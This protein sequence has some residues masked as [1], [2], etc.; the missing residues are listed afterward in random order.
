MAERRRL[1]LFVFDR[2][3]DYQALLEQDAEQAARRHR[4]ELTVHFADNRL[5]EQVE[6]IR[7]AVA[8]DAKRSVDAILVSP[9]SEVALTPF[10]QMAA[11][12]GIA[13]VFLNR[14]TDAMNDLRDQHRGVP[15][16]SVSADQD[17]VGVVHARQ[18]GELWRPGDECIYIQGP[19]GTS[20]SRKRLASTERTLSGS[21]KTLTVLHGDWSRE[22]G[23][24]VMAQY[25]R[26]LSHA[27]IRGLVVASQNDAMAI[28]AREALGQWNT[29]RSS[30]TLAADFI[31]CDGSPQF[32]QALVSSGKLSATVVIPPV[33]GRAIDELV[34]SDRTGQVP[35]SEII[36]PVSSYPS[37]GAIRSLRSG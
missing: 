8:S 29:A 36:V 19:L 25:L 34:A 27:Q 32:G 37:I 30:A 20:S 13:W 24:S 4:L 3:N 12:A 16:F 17:E 1:A 33:A 18:I 15:L 5:S 7:S 6:Q 31:G 2:N 26:M 11:R 23:Q 21:G 10:V 22:G 9:V 14:W 35:A 28:G